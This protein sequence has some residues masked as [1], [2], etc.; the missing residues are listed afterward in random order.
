MAGNGKYTKFVSDDPAVASKNVRLGKLFKGRGDT[1][2]P[3]AIYVETGDPDGARVA[4]LEGNGGFDNNLGQG[5]R[6]MLQ[7]SAPIQDA[8]ILNEFGAPVDL[9]Y[10]TAP[11]LAEGA[12]VVWA[13]AGDPVNPFMPDLRSPGP[14]LT[15]ATSDSN[16][17]DAPAAA[18]SGVD[19]HFESLGKSYVPGAPG[20]GTASPTTT[21]APLKTITSLGQGAQPLGTSD[22]D[23]TFE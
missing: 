5:A 7:P 8:V 16:M 21:I 15:E 4:L 11:D 10:G 20:T 13:Q 19:E 9:N 2:N 1:I 18:I 23:K 14:H 22:V 17:A 12:D 6:E 3:Y